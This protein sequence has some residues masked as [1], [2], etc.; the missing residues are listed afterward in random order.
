VPP[1]QALDRRGCGKHRVGDEQH[2]SGPV[3]SGV[4]KNMEF[5]YVSV[6]FELH[7]LSMA[8]WSVGDE[9][10]KRNWQNGSLRE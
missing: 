4:R 3:M 2:S 9:L 5:G 7:R 10:K 1:P 8:G 6:E